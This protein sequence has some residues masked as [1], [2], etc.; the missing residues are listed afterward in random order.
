MNNYPFC[1][2]CEE[3]ALVAGGKMPENHMATWHIGKCDSCGRK[4][5]VT[6]PRDFGYPKLTKNRSVRLIQELNN[7]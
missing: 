5:A 2:V 7:K 4:Q 6:D 3:C 1:W